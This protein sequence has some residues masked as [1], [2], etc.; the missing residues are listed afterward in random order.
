MPAP[1]RRSGHA[2]DERPARPTDCRPAPLAA[3]LRVGLARAARRL[4]AEKSDG[5]LSDSQY[6]VLFLLDRHGPMSPG[7]LAA[8]ERVRPPSMTRTVAALAG[9]ALVSRTA[10]PTDGRQQIIA[11]TD[12]GEAA[13]RE[14]RRRRDAWLARRLA[15]LSADEREVLGRAAVLLRRI[16]EA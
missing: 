14:T 16:A 12:R 2:L 9:A 1:T 4:R 3:D 7:D 10:S 5:Q 6:S 13:V 15:E 11:L 8:H